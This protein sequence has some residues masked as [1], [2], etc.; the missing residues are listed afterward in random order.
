[1]AEL[2]RHRDVL[3]RVLEAAIQTLLHPMSDLLQMP[4]TKVTG[5]CGTSISTTSRRV[6]YTACRPHPKYLKPPICPI[7]SLMSK[8]PSS[9][10]VLNMR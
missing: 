2:K 1:M 8:G 5:L 4:R 9:P 3:E 7:T 6:Q 10:Q